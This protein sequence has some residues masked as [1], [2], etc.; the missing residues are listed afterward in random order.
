M[1]TD[2]FNRWFTMLVNLSVLAGIVLV[3]I[4]I[5]LT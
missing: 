5:L 2:K 4:Q 1:I 3:A